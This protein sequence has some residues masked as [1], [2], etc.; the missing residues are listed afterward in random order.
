MRIGK[1][2]SSGALGTPRKIEN[3]LTP[4]RSGDPPYHI[5]IISPGVFVIT[6]KLSNKIHLTSSAALGQECMTQYLSEKSS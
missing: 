1:K 2:N 5:L 4:A 3:N 6:E